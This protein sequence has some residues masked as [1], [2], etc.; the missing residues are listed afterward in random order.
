MSSQY[1]SDDWQILGQSSVRYMYNLG[2][3]EK[4]DVYGTVKY[5]QHGKWVRVDLQ[6]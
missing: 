3:S 6:G 1:V 4:G 5:T 2:L